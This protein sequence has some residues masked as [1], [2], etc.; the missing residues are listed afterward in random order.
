MNWQLCWFVINLRPIP[1]L[2]TVNILKSSWIPQECSWSE[3]WTWTWIKSWCHSGNITEITIRL[4]VWVKWRAPTLSLLN[5]QSLYRYWLPSI[6]CC[7]ESIPRWPPLVTH[8]PVTG[9]LTKGQAHNAPHWGAGLD[10]SC[11]EDYLK[12]SYMPRPET[13]RWETE[14]HTNSG[15]SQYKDIQR[16]W[17]GISRNKPVWR[18]KNHKIS[19]VLKQV[20]DFD[21]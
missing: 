18:Q 6:V 15:R 3:R 11:E 17:V 10:T 4:A 14:L 20:C 13:G 1:T 16:I 5:G 2:W 19:E 7:A 8:W 9:P 21:V 12:V